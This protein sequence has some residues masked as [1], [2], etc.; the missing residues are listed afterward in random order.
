[1]KKL[2]LI[3]SALMLTFTSCDLKDKV[4]DAINENIPPVE[5]EVSEGF[6]FDAT[7]LEVAGTVSETITIDTADINDKIDNASNENVK[8]EEI[9]LDDLEIKLADGS[10]QANFD[11]LDSLKL[12]ISS[13][14]S[15][16]ISIDFGTI[17]KGVNALK[18]PDGE[19]DSIL[20]L[21]QG[22]DVGNITIDI[23]MDTNTAVENNIDLELV[24]TLLAQLAIEL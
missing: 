22:S 5:Q 4:E 7:E 1:M 23:E 14:G 19:S 10:E 24:S 20:N 18:L 15:E 11:F 12:N 2:L 13:G 9:T 21:I 3:V 17:P 6:T 8:I 16:P